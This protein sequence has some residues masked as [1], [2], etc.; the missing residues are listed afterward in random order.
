[1]LYEVITICPCLLAALSLTSP[2]IQAEERCATGGIARAVSIQ[3]VLDVR[4]AG[5]N[6]WQAATW[7]QEFCPGDALRTGASSRAA[8]QLYPETIIRL[9]Q[10]SS[11]VF[12]P[13]GTTAGTTWLELLKGAAHP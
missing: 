9:D 2:G 11:L 8:I 13:A 10:S 7:N 12:T 4:F 3:G 5:D 1:M 6:D